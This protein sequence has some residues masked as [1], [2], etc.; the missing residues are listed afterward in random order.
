MRKQ[1]P[2]SGAAAAE[3]A[4]PGRKGHEPPRVRQASAGCLRRGRRCRERAEAAPP[5]APQ[6]P[7][8]SAPSGWKRGPTRGATSPPS[9]VIPGRRTPPTRRQ[10]SSPHQRQR[11]RRPRRWPLL[12]GRGRVRPPFLLRQRQRRRTGVSLPSPW[13][14]SD[15][16]PAGRWERTRE[17]GRERQRSERP[18]QKK[19]GRL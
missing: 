6:R 3:R 4:T 2:A 19:G 18:K 12:T 10:R 9:Q 8:G 11:R 7:C 17:R 1:P 16:S 15:H 14:W 13:T 5:S